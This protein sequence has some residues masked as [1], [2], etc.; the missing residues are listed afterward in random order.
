[1]DFHLTAHKGTRVHLLVSAA[2]AADAAAAVDGGA[3]I[4]DAKDPRAGALGAVPDATLREI[5]AA[6]A[7]SRPLSAALGDAAD[8]SAVERAARDAAAAGAA[9]VKFGF[10]GVRDARRAAALLG[11]AVRGAAEGGGACVIA[12]A[13]ADAGRVAALDPL[14]VVEAAACAGAHGALLDT[15]R[16]EHGGLFALRSRGELAAWVAE[17]R[18]A[19]LLVALAGRLSSG[20]LVAVRELG[21]DIAGVRGAACVGGRGGRVSAALVRELR[22]RCAPREAGLVPLP[23]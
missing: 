19:S 17:A 13:Y 15:A 21:A 8:E 4:V 20:D 7:G 2:S 22:A 3:D 14:A 1:M 12:V 11:A 9:Y 5:A 10:A 18:A 6:V 16:K 23:A